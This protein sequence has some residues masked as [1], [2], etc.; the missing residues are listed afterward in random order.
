MEVGKKADDNVDGDQSK[1]D[2]EDYIWDGDGDQRVIRIVF[3]R[4][5][6]LYCASQGKILQIEYLI[7]FFIGNI[8]FL[9]CIVYRREKFCRLSVDCLILYFIGIKSYD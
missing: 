4:V 3:F 2:Q 7:L 5:F 1:D 8:N 6:I 9:Y